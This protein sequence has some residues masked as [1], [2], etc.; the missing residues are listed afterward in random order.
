MHYIS[1]QLKSELP[2]YN[3]QFLA[4]FFRD[5]IDC[6][7]EK[8]HTFS[9]KKNIDILKSELG[10]KKATGGWD[11]KEDWAGAYDGSCNNI[12]WINRTRLIIYIDDDPAQWSEWFNENNHENENA[13]LC[14][15]IQKCVDKKLK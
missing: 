5:P 3:F 12:T 8:N 11:G 15:A 14:P 13:K 6:S 7:K 9:L 10:F 1:N 2:W 4:V